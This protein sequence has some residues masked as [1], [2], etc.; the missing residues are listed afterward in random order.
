MA[1]RLVLDYSARLEG[2]D[3]RRI[4][5]ASWVAR[6]TAPH[7]HI[8]P[9]TT[10]IDAEHFGEFYYEGDD[11]YAWHLGSVR[12]AKRTYPSY[13]ATGGGG[14]VLLVIPELE[15]AVVF[16]GG[17]YGQGGIWGRWGNE[18]VGGEIVPALR[19]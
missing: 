2:W 9:A 10:G 14:Q 13:A 18:I 11:G 12:A 19:R 1:H 17:N 3:G 6:S 5:D 7:F 15:M 16:T 4:V 8:S